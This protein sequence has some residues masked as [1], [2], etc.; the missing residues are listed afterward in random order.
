[1]TRDVRT[2]LESTAA[3]YELRGELH[4]VPPHAVYE[5]VVD[6]QRAV[7]KLA[8]GPEADPATEARVMERV[9]R[10]TSVPVPEVLDVGPDWFLAAWH[11]GVPDEPT[12]G[13]ERARTMGAGLATVHRE[14]TFEAAGHFTTGGTGGLVL[15]SRESW[16][17]TLRALVADCRR[18]LEPYGYAGVAEEVSAFLRERPDALAGA[19]EPVLIHGNYLREH[20]G[21]AGGEVTCVIDFEHAMAGDGEYDYWATAL[22]TFVGANAPGGDLGRRAFREGYESV[23]R[24]P[25]GFDRRSGVYR[26]VL[27]VTYLRSLYLQGQWERPAADRRAESFAGNI[28]KRLERLRGRG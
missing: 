13:A 25:D 10:E 3:E 4:A 28:R 23:R 24:L 15:E 14:T 1:M 17:E 2:I 20:V 7:C 16:P 9:R 18:F 27:G 11:D 21:V 5:A 12:V 19:G 8:R 26:V 6:G 22:P